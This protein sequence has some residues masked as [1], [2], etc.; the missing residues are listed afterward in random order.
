MKFACGRGQVSRRLPGNRRRRRRNSLNTA[1]PQFM[2]PAFSD[3]DTS[4]RMATTTS[5]SGF[6]ER[7]RF[8]W[9]RSKFRSGNPTIQSIGT[10]PFQTS[11]RCRLTSFE[12]TST[13]TWAA[14][15]LDRIVVTNYPSVRAAWADLLRDQVDMLYEVSADAWIP[16]WRDDR[17]GIQLYPAISVYVIAFNPRSPTLQSAAIRRALNAAIDRAAFVRDGLNG[18]RSTIVRSNLAATLGLHSDLPGFKLRSRPQAATRNSVD[19]CISS[20]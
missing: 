20:V 1:L 16:D 12:P 11:S 19:L 10:G 3:V 5:K 9:R 2:G 15:Q 17:F 18:P 6:D 13:T 8:C 7:R 4:R 14:R